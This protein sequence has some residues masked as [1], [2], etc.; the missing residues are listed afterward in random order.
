MVLGNIAMAAA[1][2]GVRVYVS[3]YNEGSRTTPLTAT[4]RAEFAG[5]AAAIAG[6]NPGFRDVIV[7]NEPNLNRFWLPQFDARGKG[8]SAPAYLRLLAATY[9]SLKVAA[10]DVRV[11]GGALAPRGIDRPYTGRDT[12]SPTRFLRELGEAYRRSGRADPIMDGLSFHPYPLNSSVPVDA[13]PPDGDHLG[14]IDQD[15]LV[16]LLGKAFDGT[17]QLGRGLPIL[18]DEFGIESQIR[19]RPGPSRRRG[20]R[21]RTGARSTWLTAS[22]TSRGCCSSTRTTRRPGPAGSPASSMPTG[23]R[24]RRSSPCGGR[25]RTPVPARSAFARS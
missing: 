13:V 5:Y 9:D 20:R 6:A 12:I 16:N 1:L 25:S 2:H 23:R 19:G 7:G 15:R 11:W 22:R 18:Y 17:A 3:V 8:A 10:P 4:A 14:L 24:R 21:R